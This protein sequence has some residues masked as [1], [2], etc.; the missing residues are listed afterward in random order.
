MTHYALAGFCAIASDVFPSFVIPYFTNQSSNDAFA[1]ELDS[2]YIIDRFVKFEPAHYQQLTF[3][4]GKLVRTCG[5]V[6][7]LA[8]AEDPYLTAIQNRCNAD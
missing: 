5:Q 2:K 3:V 6:G 4:P 7:V 8:Y 1:Q